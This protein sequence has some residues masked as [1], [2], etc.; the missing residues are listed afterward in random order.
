MT[1]DHKFR[2]AGVPP[3]V[4]HAGGDAPQYVP[5]PPPPVGPP[6]P[7][8]GQ[9]APPPP[10]AGQ[11]PWTPPVKPG[12]IP[13]RPL[14][15]GTLLGAPFQVLRRNPGPTLGSALIIQFAIGIVTALIVGAAVLLAVTRLDSA[16]AADRDSIQAGS[17][18]I[19][20]LSTLIPLAVALVTSALLQAILVIEVSRE[21]LG[22]KRRLGELW[23]AAGKRIWPLAL[24][25]LLQAAVAVVVLGVVVGI[26]A[27]LATLGTTGVVFA[28]IVGILAFLGLVVASAW[29]TTKLSLVPCVIV[30]ERAGVRA[31]IVR[32]WRLTD[33]SFWRTLGTEWLVATIV[34]VAAQVV[35]QPISFLFGLGMGVF[36]PNG[37]NSSGSPTEWLLF[38]GVYLLVGAIQLVFGAISSVV[39]AATVSVIYVD[40]RIRKEGLDLE[41]IRFVED[42]ESGRTTPDDDPF[43]VTGRV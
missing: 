16:S 25:T 33:R 22:E 24:W 15:F 4:P 37:T 26:V 10:G 6:A 38:G 12:L 18:A 19:I 1:D 2:G 7:Q 17:V 11:Q 14:G 34:S 9:Y 20:L 13:L 21:I 27:L 42:R 31:A 3:V 40:L 23:L 35:V 36:A 29:L 41:L 5:P 32:S 30:L 43:R 28:V 8:Y 39:Q